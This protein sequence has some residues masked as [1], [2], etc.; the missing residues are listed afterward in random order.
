M[1]TPPS[2]LLT[3]SH[4]GPS[5]TFGWSAEYHG[6][7][8]LLQN[9]T[10]ALVDLCLNL[11][12]CTPSYTLP[13]PVLAFLKCLPTTNCSPQLPPW[14]GTLRKW[15]G[16]VSGQKT[17][18]DNQ[19]NMA[20]STDTKDRYLWTSS[21]VRKSQGLT[22]D[23][24]RKHCFVSYEH[25]SIFWASCKRGVASWQSPHRSFLCLFF[26]VEPD[27]SLSIL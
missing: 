22:G 2:P 23:V 25:T 7:G 1:R 16:T 19:R 4:K 27:K 26:I 5:S 10:H 15:E 18:K 8:I 11:W 9:R 14:S 12:V 21:H 13:D 6:T 17:F 3:T 20:M 24:Y